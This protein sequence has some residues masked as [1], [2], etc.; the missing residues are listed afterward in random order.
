M[1]AQSRRTV[2]LEALAP[3]APMSSETLAFRV[4][5]RDGALNADGVADAATIER[6]CAGV[7]ATLS[8]LVR[9]TQRKE[10]TMKK[11][12]GAVGLFQQYLSAIGLSV[13]FTESG[14][15][16]WI[17]ARGKQ[18]G[19]LLVVPAGVVCAYLLTAAN[20]GWVITTKEEEV[21][22]GASLRARERVSR[23]CCRAQRARRAFLRTSAC[24]FVSYVADTLLAQL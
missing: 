14:Y 13:W 17:V 4:P 1:G 22:A 23:A 15:G 16:T 11:Y 3:A 19:E 24:S 10:S 5:G 20:G 8:K 9:E 21:Q 7:T 2:H 18:S 12:R 6:M